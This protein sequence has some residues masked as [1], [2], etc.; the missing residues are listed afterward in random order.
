MNAKAIDDRL[1]WSITLFRELP[2]AEVDAIEA[3]C[4]LS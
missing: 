3:L 1:K 2:N 4:Q